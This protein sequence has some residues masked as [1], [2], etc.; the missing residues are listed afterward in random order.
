MPDETPLDAAAVRALAA[1]ADLPL[2]ADR[3]E[4]VAGQLATW[5]VAANELNRK[6]AAPEHLTVTPITV[7]TH[8]TTPEGEDQ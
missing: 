3:E 2:P 6:M 7:F 8:P 1:A 5:L 4:L